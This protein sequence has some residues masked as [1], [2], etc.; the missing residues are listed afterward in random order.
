MTY[1]QEFNFLPSPFDGLYLAINMTYTD[2]DSTFAFE[3]NESFT[4]PFR[5]LS[6]QQR[7]IS[8]GF[9][10]GKI[11]A[12]LSLSSRGDYLDWL[13]DEEGDIDTISLGNSRFVDD[14]SQLD[15]T[16]KYKI[17]DNLT[18]K[19]EGINLTDEP[20]YYYWG[21]KDRLSQYD[22]YG[23]TFSVGFRYTY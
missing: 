10:Q 22:E 21:Y 1:Q 2:G 19:A 4:T 6:D 20:E 17:N 18:I 15:F 13:A 5:K 23:T 9:D 3:D 7:N 12:R 16:L 11:D 8:I 14:H